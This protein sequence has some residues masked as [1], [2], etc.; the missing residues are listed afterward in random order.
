M[1]KRVVVIGGGLGGIS[2]AIHARLAGADVTLV[3]A[4][5]LGGKAAGIEIGGYRLDPGPSIVI[6]PEIYEAVF[7]AAGKRMSD[8]LRFQ[9]LDPITRVYFEGGEGFIDLPAD[10]EACV[11]TLRE[12]S[13]PDANALRDLLSRLDKVAPHVEASIFRGPIHQPWQLLNPH[14]VAMAR[15]LGAVTNYKALID[16]LFESPLARAFFYG[17]PSYGGQSYNGSAAGALL[18]PYYMLAR[19]VFY[20]EGGV[21]AIPTALAK[22]ARELGVAVREDSPVTGLKTEQKRVTS[23]ELAQGETISCDALI[24]NVDRTTTRQWLNIHPTCAP[25]F[26]YF[27][28]HWG[29]KRPLSGLAHHVLL[30][31]KSFERGFEQLYNE[32]RLPD[33]PIAYL[34]VTSET[35]TNVAP[36]GCTNLFAVLTSPACESGIDWNVFQVEALARTKSMLSRFGWDIQDSDLDFQR[37]QTPQ[38]FQSQHGNYKGSLYGVD[39]SCRLFGILPERCIDETYANLFYC[40]ASVQPGA[41]L[42]MVTLSGKF[43]AALA[44]K[45]R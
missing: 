32:R 18:I 28:A 12:I 44:Q 9:R 11:A 27:T 22:L 10:R 17:F 39:E 2:A 43:A 34:N 30:V 38:Y 26:S 20:P 33:E 21:A 41:G 25:S 8:Y 36:P 13:G 31:P 3:E 37:I 4:H 29:V 23:V 7:A 45:Y 19:G 42:P 6:L 14:L 35:D 15:H 16:R 1:P 5:R 24:S 40:G